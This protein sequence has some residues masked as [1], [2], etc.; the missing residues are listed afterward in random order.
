M[1]VQQYLLNLTFKFLGIPYIYGGSSP[2]VGFD[3]S[4]FVI[5]ILQVFGRLP[6][7]DWTSEDLSKLFTKTDSPQIGDLA[8]YGGNHTVS[9]VMMCIGN[10][11]VI[12]ASGGDHTTLTVEDALKRNAMVKTKPMHYRSDFLFTVDTTSKITT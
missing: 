10:G 2:R 11:T 12:G 6:S 8:F 3:C 5:W 9:H 7:G 4:G 1:S